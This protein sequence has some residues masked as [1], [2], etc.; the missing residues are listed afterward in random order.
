MSVIMFF[1]FI[2]SV[3]CFSSELRTEAACS[4]GKCLQLCFAFDRFVPFYVLITRC[5]RAP[6]LKVA[7]SRQKT[8]TPLQFFGGSSYCTN[9]LHDFWD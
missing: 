9:K 5:H 2:F 1:T 8:G 4:R 3:L 7:F 6:F